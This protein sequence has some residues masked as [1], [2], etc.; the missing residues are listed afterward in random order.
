MPRSSA[1]RTEEVSLQTLRDRSARITELKSRLGGLVE[2]D[3]ML[4]ARDPS[5]SATDDST[6]STSS[7]RPSPEDHAAAAFPP[8]L[9]SKIKVRSQALLSTLQALSHASSKINAS[10]AALQGDTRIQNLAAQVDARRAQAFSE[11]SKLFRVEYSHRQEINVPDDLAILDFDTQWSGLGPLSTTG[12]GISGQQQGPAGHT[13]DSLHMHQT[14]NTDNPGNPGN[15]ADSITTRGIPR[16]TICDCTIDPSTWQHAFDEGGDAPESSPEADR[17]TSIAICYAAEIVSIASTILDVPLRY[18]ITLR[19][20]YSTI[21]DAKP[22]VAGCRT[23]PLFVDSTK[24]G[25]A[26]FAIGVFL[27]NKNINLLTSHLDMATDVNRF[28]SESTKDSIGIALVQ[29]LTR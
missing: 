6:P 15:N 10:S 22:N 20:T 27:L 11:I 21:A 14:N 9:P 24:D 25:R 3:E 13:P 28:A 7:R 5:R 8:D 29:L 1:A 26:K 2:S 19:G 23:F 12:Y 18:P 17:E 16:V 4:R